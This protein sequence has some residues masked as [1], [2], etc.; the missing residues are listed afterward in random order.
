MNPNTDNFIKIVREYCAWSESSDHDIFQARMFLLLLMQGVFD[1]EKFPGATV[2]EKE[3]PSGK[4]D[5]MQFHRIPFQ[6]YPEVFSTMDIDSKE[7]V[8]GDLL[9]DLSDIYCDLW[10][11]LQALEQGNREYAIAFWRE[12]YI[13]HWGGHAASA[14]RAVDEYCRRKENP[15]MN[16]P[17]WWE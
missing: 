15:Y 12:N 5:P 6:Y 13:Y 7:V 3:Y 4:H 1:L 10:H 8:M 2:T 11:G 9:D 14:L 16:D 17:F